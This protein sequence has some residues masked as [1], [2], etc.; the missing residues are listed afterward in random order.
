MIHNIV[1]FALRQRFLVL[2]LAVFLIIAG[3]FLFSVCP[4]TP[5]PIFRLRWWR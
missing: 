1:Q 2:M 5:T 4:W 3:L